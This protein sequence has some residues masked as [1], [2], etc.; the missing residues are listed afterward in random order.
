VPVVDKK[1]PPEVKTYI[2]ARGFAA[3]LSRELSEGREYLLDI[4]RRRR[5]SRHGDQLDHGNTTDRTGQ[6]GLS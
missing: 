5:L 3:R 2:S 6:N 4:Q 1:A